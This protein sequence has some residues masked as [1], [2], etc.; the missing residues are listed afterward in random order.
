MI[1]GFAADLVALHT[2]RW[3]NA[4]RSVATA[5]RS[6]R[7][8]FVTF[9]PRYAP[10]VDLW[11][12]IW[13]YKRQLCV[14]NKTP[15][16]V[17]RRNR[18]FPKSF[19]SRG[20]LTASGVGN[21]RISLSPSSARI[22]FQGLISVRFGVLL[23]AH[24]RA[25]PMCCDSI[26]MLAIARIALKKL[27]LIPIRLPISEKPSFRDCCAGHSCPESASRRALHCV[28]QYSAAM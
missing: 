14:F 4:S 1:L 26:R 16:D 8:D 2:P 25:E 22:P 21:S 11:Q 7:R 10:I 28:F 17:P 13:A 12:A 5:G 15:L 18:H 27:S 9:R 23:G 3:S 24:A 6:C 20:V 19:S